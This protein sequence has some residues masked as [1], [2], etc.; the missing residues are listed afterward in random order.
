MCEEINNGKAGGKI[1]V[2]G[3][4]QTVQ[5]SVHSSAQLPLKSSVQ[6]PNDEEE[7][8]NWGVDE[9]EGVKFSG[10]GFDIDARLYI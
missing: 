5:S 1:G 7:E 4:T 9:V 6:L 8:G 3:A 10:P 2:G